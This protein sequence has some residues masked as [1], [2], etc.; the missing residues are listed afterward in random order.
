MP[1]LF[2]FA[3]AG[4]QRLGGYGSKLWLAIAA[5]AVVFALDLASYHVGIERTKLGNSALF[6]NSGS[7]VLMAWGIF[8]L[9][10]KPT[11]GET[12]ALAAALL[13]AAIMFG[14]SLEIGPK[15]LTGDLFCLLAGMCY[16]VYILIL[17]RARG[18]LGSWALLAW[19][20]VIGAPLLLALALALGEPVWP[21]DWTPLI[22]LAITSQVIGQGTLV[23]A[24]RHLRPLTIGLVLLTQPGI[25]ALAGWLAF[26]ETLGFWDIVGMALVAAALVIARAGERPAAP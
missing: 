12:A 4:R 7:L 13:G 21:H 26:G 17:Q 20:S 6:G 2:A 1:L 16:A 14:R 15:T 5:A 25:A 22:G 11:G 10:R 18:S 8:A 24:L 19:S 23:Y 3:A 9:R